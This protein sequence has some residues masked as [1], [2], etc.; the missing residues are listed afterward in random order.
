M[1]SA[2]VQ[3]AYEGWTLFV[4]GSFTG[5]ESKIFSPFGTKPTYTDMQQV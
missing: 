4:A 5:N 2:K 3:M 1:G